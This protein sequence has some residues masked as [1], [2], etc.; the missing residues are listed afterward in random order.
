MLFGAQDFVLRGFDWIQ[1]ELALFPLSLAFLLWGGVVL[2]KKSLFAW[3]LL[4]VSGDSVF[5]SGCSLGILFVSITCFRQ[6]L[7]LKHS[8]FLIDV[9]HIFGWNLPHLFLP[10]VHPF[11][12][13]VPCCKSFLHGFGCSFGQP[14]P[15]TPYQHIDN[16]LFDKRGICC[17]AQ[18]HVVRSWLPRFTYTLLY[19]SCSP[20]RHRIYICPGIGCSGVTVT[21]LKNT[22]VVV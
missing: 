17:W 20:S 22:N 9:G 4:G 12:V 15:L 7:L 2:L 13:L 11:G 10:M 14:L 21:Q 8:P 1:A 19:T 16:Y 18:L 5:E 3:V 6:Q